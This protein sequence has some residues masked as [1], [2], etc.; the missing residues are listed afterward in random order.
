MLAELLGPKLGVGFAAEL[1]HDE[2]HNVA[3]DARIDVLIGPIRLR[4]GRAVDAALVRERRPADVRLVVVGGDVHDLRDVARQFRELGELARR[5][6]LERGLELE[7]RED[8]HQVRVAASL[9]VAVDR[10]LDVANAVRHRRERVG[11]RQLRVVVAVDA[12]YHARRGV[13]VERL[14]GR[15]QDRDQFVGQ[16]AAVGVAECQRRSAAVSGRSQG[17]QRIRRVVLVAVEVMLGVVHPLSPVRAHVRDRV[18]DHLE[19][20]FGRG[21]QHGFDVEQPAL[22]EDRD[23]GRMRFDERVEVGIGRGTVVPVARHP[24]RGE[25]GVLPHDRFGRGEEVGVL[26][27]GPGPAAFYVGEAELVEPLADLDLVG[28]RD[29][30]TFPL[31]S[32]AKGRVV[33]KYAIGAHRMTPSGAPSP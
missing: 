6:G 32:V 16:R 9:A 1:A 3:D 8:A 31:G 28:E 5:H 24:E 22:A 15:P 7:V 18:A 33:E 12:P 14:A 17:R 4:N 10:A 26:W 23:D 19:V 13:A 29:D 30:Q 20:F 2:P 27:V 11:H 21:A 25:L